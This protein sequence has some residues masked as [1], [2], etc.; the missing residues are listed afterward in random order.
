MA[1]VD[2]SRPLAAPPTLNQ[3]LE[4]VPQNIDQFVLN[5]YDA[6][7]FAQELVKERTAPIAPAAGVPVKDN[8]GQIDEGTYGGTQLALT[9]IYDRVEQGYDL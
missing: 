4:T 7:V 8:K 9:E 6:G 2:I 3:M 5:G 1:A